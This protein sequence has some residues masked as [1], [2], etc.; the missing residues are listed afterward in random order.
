M[1]ENS[2]HLKKR[3]ENC[4]GD[5][6]AWIYSR[7]EVRKYVNAAQFKHL[8]EFKRWKNLNVWQISASTN[9]L[10]LCTS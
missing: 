4:R 5:G 6:K 1:A 2:N 3:C 8:V 9:Q 7:S 10:L